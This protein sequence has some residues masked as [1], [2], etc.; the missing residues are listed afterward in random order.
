MVFLA[1]SLGKVPSIWAPLALAGLW[2]LRWLLHRVFDRVGY[3]ELL[4]LLGLGGLLAGD[5][6]SC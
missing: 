5:T 4:V 3:G 1:I 2:P 6:H